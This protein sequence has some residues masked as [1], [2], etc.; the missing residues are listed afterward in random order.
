MTRLFFRYI[1]DKLRTLIFALALIALM[2]FMGWLWGVSWREI[3]Y[4][5][6]L[7]VIL[8]AVACI[9]GFARFSARHRKL[10]QAREL[11][12]I[13]EDC[14]PPAASMAEEDYQ[15]LIA[16]LRAQRIAAQNAGDARYGEMLDYFTLWTHQIKTPI[17]AMW[18]L[19]Q[20]D[21]ERRGGELENE[22]FRIEQ[23][24][25]M[26]LSYMRLGSDYSDFVLRSYA[27]DS[28]IKQT[29]RK[30][31]RQFIGKGISLR[32]EG[33]DFHTVTD[34]KWLG[35][36]IEQLLTNALK[37]TPSGGTISISTEGT[38]LIIEDTGIGIAPEDL[39][40]VFQK[41]YTGYNGRADKKSTGI[42]LYLCKWVLDKLGCGIRI[43][44]QPGQ[45]T[46]VE[47]E[48]EEK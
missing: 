21:P 38:R 47:I 29:L 22:L 10:V 44:S 32:Y 4:G 46:R 31:S 23:Y 14:L 26:A 33:T 48:L 37:Y 25:E 17:S 39:P 13:R 34:E 11:L 45:G 43:Q 35:F 18:L 7:G 41:G 3:G 20:S 30:L 12:L 2:A 36:V 15:E 27:L 8:G 16:L 5:V 9:L 28:I 19:L 6:L 24:V 42:G 40:R 1:K